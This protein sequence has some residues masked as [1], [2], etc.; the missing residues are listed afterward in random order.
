MIGGGRKEDKLERQRA[1]PGEGLGIAAASLL[2][3]P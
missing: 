2:S 3:D 1:V